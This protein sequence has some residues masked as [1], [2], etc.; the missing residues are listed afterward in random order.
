MQV[1]GYMQLFMRGAQLM[2]IVS[3]YDSK[4]VRIYTPTHLPS[5]L[6]P[7]QRYEINCMFQ[8]SHWT[9]S[10]PYILMPKL[11][12]LASKNHA[13]KEEWRVSNAFCI[14][15][16]EI[17]EWSNVLCRYASGIHGALH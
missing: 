8:A 11:C 2:S 6:H 10:V 4:Y 14:R 13:Y 1:E 17:H 9:Q 16:A 12:A 3:F 7:C 5:T 15:K